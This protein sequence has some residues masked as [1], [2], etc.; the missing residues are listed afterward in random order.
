MGG[1]EGSESGRVKLMGVCERYGGACVCY[2]GRGGVS[3]WRGG[4]EG[5]ISPY[6][7]EI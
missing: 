6:D 1:W 2:D 3:G 5:G 7:V 4:R